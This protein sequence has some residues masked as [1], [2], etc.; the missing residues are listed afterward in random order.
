MQKDVFADNV[1]FLGPEY[2]MVDGRLICL[3]MEG[4]EC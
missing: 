3:S 4:E 1:D 2:Y